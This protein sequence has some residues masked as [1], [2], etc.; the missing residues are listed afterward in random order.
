MALRTMTEADIPAVNQLHRDVWWPERS[1][2]GWRWLSENPVRSEVDSPIGMI[3]DDQ[4]GHPS[5]FLGNFT[6]RFVQGDS[7]FYGTTGFSVIVPPRLRGATR[8]LLPYFTEL[9]GMQVHYTVNAN[10]LSS[11]MYKRY[12]MHP[13]PLQ[14]H[15]LKLSWIINPMSCAASRLLRKLVEHR[16]DMVRWL[17]EPLMP[18][19][20]RLDR[21][22][23]GSEVFVVDDLSETS[24]YARFWKALR[25]EGRFMADRS[26]EIMRWRMSD[27]DLTHPF[28]HLAVVKDG[29]I[30]G[31]ALALM[32]KY[33]SIEPPT[34]EIIDLEALSGHRHAIQTLMQALI[35]VA[36]PMGA[37]KLRLQTLSPALLEDLGDLGHKARREGGYGHCHFKFA[38]GFTGHETWQPTPFDG[39]FSICLR[40][41]PR[42]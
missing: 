20:S 33:S 27:P 25:A 12:R 19:H 28:V 9:P 5:A 30:I 2:A 42:R 35:R 34:L 38:P 6:Q 24:A 23:L 17:G 39:D 14:T 22:R 3:I 7:V 37:A 26:P 11:P 32:A 40:P 15:D 29:E 21:K 8:Q 1:E 10:A 41:L 4:D 18:T 16:P 36:G 13:W 31:H